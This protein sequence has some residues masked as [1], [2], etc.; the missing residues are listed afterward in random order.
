[1]WTEEAV[2]ELITQYREHPV[3][4]N[5]KNKDFKNR[6]KKDE[7]LKQISQVM[8]LEVVDVERKINVLNTQFRR[9]HKKVLA[10]KAAGFPT[11]EFENN[12]WY[13]YKNLLFLENRYYRLRRPTKRFLQ[14]VRKYLYLY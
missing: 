3:L 10:L 7:A 8:N 13:G 1:M 5:P 14:L 11:D 4:W 9:T 6:I 12:L 2:E